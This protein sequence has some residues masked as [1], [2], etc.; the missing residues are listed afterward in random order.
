[1][2]DENA[3]SFEDAI[4]ELEGIVSYLD[5]GKADLDESLAKYEAG[6]RLLR[7]CRK[8][9]DAA[10]QKIEILRRADPETGEIQ[11]EPVELDALT[12]DESAA[13]R[14][15]TAGRTRRAKTADDDAGLV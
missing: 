4:K 14:G 10:E 7:R 1:M 15:R 6:V 12:S 2:P 3:Q 9:L 8:M 5:N 11:T 13:G